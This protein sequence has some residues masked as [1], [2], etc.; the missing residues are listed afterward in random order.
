MAI[1]GP[2]LPDYAEGVAAGGGGGGDVTAPVVT[3]VSPTPGVAPGDPGG[4]PANYA[5]ALTTPIV[6]NI[7][8]AGGLSLVVVTLTPSGGAPETV[9][10]RGAFVT[11]YEGEA[12]GDATDLTLTIRR[13]GGWASLAFRIS[14]S[15]ADGNLDA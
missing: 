7:T 2:L 5:D 8:D 10:L 6:V 13:T 12:T 15:A 9:Y 1:L 11:P 4:F 3:I 14:V